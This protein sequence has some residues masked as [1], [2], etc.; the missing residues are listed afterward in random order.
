MNKPYDKNSGVVNGTSIYPHSE[1]KL[2][3][4]NYHIINRNNG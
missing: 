4:K 2:N 3:Q 1:I